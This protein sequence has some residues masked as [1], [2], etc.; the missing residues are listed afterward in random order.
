M[1]KHNKRPVEKLDLAYSR[2][3]QDIEDVFS[4]MF[5]PATRRILEE[6]T[7]LEIQET[8]GISKATGVTLTTGVMVDPG[9]QTSDTEE[10]IE[11]ATDSSS[12]LLTPGITLTTGVDKLQASRSSSLQHFDAPTLEEPANDSDK[13]L[14]QSSTEGS[15]D[16][17]KS[18]SLDRTNLALPT[19][20]GFRARLVQDAHTI[21]EQTLYEVLWN[22]GSG[23]PNGPKVICAGYRTLAAQTRLGDKTIKR[24]LRS[25]EEKLAI[26]PIAAEQTHTSTGRTYRI[27]SFRQILE[28]R[29]QVG[30]EWVIRNRQGVT[31]TLVPDELAQ[32]TPPVVTFTPAVKQHPESTVSPA[33]VVSVAKGRVVTQTPQL[34]KVLEKDVD[35]TSSLGLIVEALRE[36]TGTTDDDAARRIYTKCREKSP[37]A[38]EEEVSYFVKIQAKRICNMRGIDNPLGLLITQVPKC[39]EGESFRQFR[40]AEKTRRESESQRRQEWRRQ[41][42]ALLDDPN[43][44]EADKNWAKLSLEEFL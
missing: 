26:E 18:H 19:V 31:L 8:A 6:T 5:G 11:T 12:P 25:L 9:H 13:V 37:D 40:E 3:R 35:K 20:I 15:F 4:D 16:T 44:S 32:R 1:A 14:S 42:E 17:S 39:F 36:S 7:T 28:R 30:L 29:R 23:D 22:G 41:A 27:Y 38:T 33:P 34:V 24:N 43:S 2:K 10:L 21:W